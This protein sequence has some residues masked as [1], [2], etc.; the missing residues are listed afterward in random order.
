MNAIEQMGGRDIGEVERRVLPEQHHVEA[1]DLGA[2]RRAEREMIAFP[3]AHRQRLDGRD[4]L[5]AAQR[6]PVRRVIGERVAAPLCL[7]QQRKGGIAADI[8]PCDRVHLDGDV[9]GH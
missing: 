1:R 8:D 7:E 5:G 9:Q 6:Q 3:V 2:G 4:H